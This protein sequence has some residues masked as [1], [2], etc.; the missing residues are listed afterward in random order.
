M[1]P[2]STETEEE[3][4]NREAMESLYF[5]LLGQ[6]KIGSTPE[7]TAKI[8]K[9]EATIRRMHGKGAEVAGAV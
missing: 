7:L 6:E 9:V 3:Q 5:N 4:I 8:N 1:K 2:Q